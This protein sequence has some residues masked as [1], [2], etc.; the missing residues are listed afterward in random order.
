MTTTTGTLSAALAR[1][2]ERFHACLG[3]VHHVASPLGAWLLLALCGTAATGGPTSPG[4]GRPARDEVV[5]ALGLDLPDAAR[6]AASLLDQPHPLVGCAGA[7]W[8]RRGGADALAGWLA[9]LPASVATG[10]LPDQAGL[11]AWARHH[12]L[13]LIDRFPVP[14]TRETALVLATALATRVS[15]QRPFD[16]APASALGPDSGWAG[17]VGRVLRTPAGPGHEQYIAMT[18]R[19]GEVAVHVGQ[20]RTGPDQHA[21][22]AGLAVVSVI[23]DPAVPAPDVLSAAYQLAPAAA[24]GV[25]P[26]QRSLFDLPLGESALWRVSEERVETTAP[27]GREEACT[28][29]LPAWSA[30]GSHDLA[31]QQLGLPAAAG[32]L[33]SLVGAGEQAYEAR[34]SVLA[35][36]HRVGFEAVA[37][38]A[39][40]VSVAYHPSRPGVRR[41]AELRFGH[42]Y[43]V[44]AV[45]TGS[46]P[47]HGLPV[48][49]AWVTEVEEAE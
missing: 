18:D 45:A 35:R 19:A 15:W 46:G 39:F 27:T 30:R 14:V 17:R 26:A 33:A 36:F 40:A 49:S 4:G 38:S 7:V 2:A 10:G 44:L 25:R 12:T 8:H 20:A 41:V 37:V 3:G 43:A 32:A 42:P 22:P 6:L 21:R 29:V 48:F 47:W 5:E 11:D 16:L 28:A 9:G 31:H 24:T 34:Q 1:Y 23:A 13:G